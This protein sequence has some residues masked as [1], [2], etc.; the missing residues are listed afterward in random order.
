VTIS[1]AAFSIA[2]GCLGDVFVR[3]GDDDLTH[4]WD[5][6]QRVHHVAHHGEGESLDRV[7]IEGGDEAALG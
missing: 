5:T 4:R 2:L 1:A 7:A 6:R 3:C